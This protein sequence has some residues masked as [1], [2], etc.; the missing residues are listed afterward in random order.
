MTSLSVLVPVYDEQHLVST[1]LARLEV[2]ETSPHLEAIQVVVVDDCSKDRT[3]E[4]LRAF[5]AERGLEWREPGEIVDGVELGAHGR[6][7]RIEWV[8]LRH[9]VNGGKG[10]PPSPRRRAPSPSSTTP[11]SSTTLAT[12]SGS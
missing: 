10:A 1:S 9:V 7:G 6:R 5:A 11:I 12:S 4:V 2:L 3:R 8:F